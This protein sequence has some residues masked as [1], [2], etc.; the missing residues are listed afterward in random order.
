V[1]NVD[2][3][4]RDGWVTGRSV[5][6]ANQP[7]A[8]IGK[9]L[10]QVASDFSDLVS[11]QVEL[12]KVELKEEAARAGRSAG[13]LTAAGACAYLALGLVSLALAWLLDDVMPRPLAFSIVGLLW[14]VVAGG[15]YLSGRQQLKALQLAPQ[16]K[17]S[18]KE[19]V[20][21]AKKQKS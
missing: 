19:D 20:E 8:S 16:T 7:G 3:R 13:M 12:A 15:L 1:T 2:M 17:V 18:L 4:D 9:L 6:E 11:T 14:A 5:A 10:G 21:W